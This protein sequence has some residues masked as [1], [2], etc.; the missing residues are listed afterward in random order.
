MIKTPTI[1]IINPITLDKVILSLKNI[2]D[3]IIINIGDE[4]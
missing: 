1:Q 4:V 3:K 2:R